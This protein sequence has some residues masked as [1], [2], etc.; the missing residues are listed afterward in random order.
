MPNINRPEYD[1]SRPR[2]PGFAARRMRIGDRLGTE[3]VGCSLWELPPGEAAY[4][5]HFHCADEEVVVVLR[6]RPTL[7]SPVG[8]RRLEEGEAVRFEPGEDGA[9]QLINETGE[10]AAFLSMSNHGT[11]D[12]VVYPDSGKIGVGERRARGGGLKRYFRAE[13]AVDYW[14]GEHAPAAE[15]RR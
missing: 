7:R 1:R 12:M 2:P 4:P 14:D 5:Y 6:G 13:D 8:R 9:H 11:P 15:A 3:L 10:E